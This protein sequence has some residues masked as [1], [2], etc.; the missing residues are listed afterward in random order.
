MGAPRPM[1]RAPHPS[2]HRSVVL[3]ATR[4]DAGAAMPPRRDPR[5]APL[6]PAND[7]E[8]HHERALGQ[9]PQGRSIRVS[10][11][12]RTGERAIVGEMRGFRAREGPPAECMDAP[13]V[14][15]AAALQ[16]PSIAGS[17]AYIVSRMAN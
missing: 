2:A 16:P 6:H 3:R 5:P 10:T 17:S 14:G 12:S 8:K 7:H 9:L 1:A 4:P 11:A 13:R 15:K